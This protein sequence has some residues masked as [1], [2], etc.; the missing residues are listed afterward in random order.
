MTTPPEPVLEAALFT[1]YRALVYARNLTGQP[2][3]EAAKQVYHLTDAIH[4]I[5]EML[6]AWP[7]SSVDDLRM[8]FGCFDHRRWVGAP[9]FVAMFDH[10]LAELTRA[11]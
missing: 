5:P 2:S 3:A 11:A 6:I 9:D 4:P 1:L 10:K 8:Y 7:R